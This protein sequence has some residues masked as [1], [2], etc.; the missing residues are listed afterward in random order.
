LLKN[1]AQSLVEGAVE[2]VVGKEN[3]SAFVSMIED[4]ACNL[5]SN[6][7]SAAVQ[8]FVK[9]VPGVFLPVVHIIDSA[10]RPKIKEV[11]EL[12]H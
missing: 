5:F 4:R 11:L 6:L 7:M 9:L 10:I 3:L 1:A 12:S 8:K 2:E